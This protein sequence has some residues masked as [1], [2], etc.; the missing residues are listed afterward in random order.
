MRAPGNFQQAVRYYFSRW[1]DKTSLANVAHDINNATPLTWSD[2]TD[3]TSISAFEVDADSRVH[4]DSQAQLGMR[5]NAR[6]Y[7]NAAGG[8]VTQAF[9]VANRNMY[10][11]GVEELHS[12]AETATGTATAV[13]THD[14]AGQ[15]AGTGT[16]VMTNTFN[17]KATA[18]T[19]Q[20]G[21]LLAVD[22]LGRPSAGLLMAPGDRLSVLVG[23]TATITALAGVVLTVFER[24]GGK[25]LDY[26]YN[27]QANASLATQ[28][29]ALANRDLIITGVYMSWG[30]AATNGGAVTLDVGIDTGTTAPGS[31]TTILA[32]AQ[33][34]K[35]AANTPIS[36][37]LT[38]T[39]A[40]LKMVA[41]NRLSVKYTGTL[42][43]LAGVVVTVT[44]TSVG[45][46]VYIGE[47]Q[48]TFTLLANGSLAAAQ[49]FFIADRDYEVV[50]ASAVW[51]TAGSDAGAVAGDITID[52]GVAAPGSGAS[53]LAGTASLKAAANTVV[54]PGVNT[55]RRQRLMS[56]GDLLTFKTTGTLTALAGVTVTVS[57][58]PR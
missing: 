36:V 10:V 23:G 24:P 9:F 47:Q 22:G 14:L 57:L 41:G 58:Q 13:I 45:G 39:A 19:A 33:S 51:S 15:A 48:A 1:Y 50:D 31:G 29:F 40:N 28:S 25:E 5:Q 43:A 8:L 30:T 7:F 2:S 54:I 53:C 37:P 52:K 49:G 42:T 46:S 18:N 35:G 11:T 4:L 3:T 34:V 21:T 55:S 27:M 6:F 44:A 12:T 20:T 26:V 32:A 17:L 56:Q 38:A 16:V